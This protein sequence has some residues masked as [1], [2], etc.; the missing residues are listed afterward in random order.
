MLLIQS[1]SH[2][3]PK[4]SRSGRSIEDRYP[5]TTFPLIVYH[6]PSV[7]DIAGRA[8]QAQK[9][10][11]KK[12]SRRVRARTESADPP[13]IASVETS[14][15]PTL[16]IAKEVDVQVATEAGA[17]AASLLVEAIQVNSLSDFPDC[18][19][20]TDSSYTR[21]HRLPS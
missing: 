3:P 5:Y 17:A 4:R 20:H 8:K 15:V 19:L 2:A 10:V 14:A 7:D 16:P 21:L 12:T 18:Y 1:E 13:M 11:V 6:A 9:K